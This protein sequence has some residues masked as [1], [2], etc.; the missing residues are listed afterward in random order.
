MRAALLLAVLWLPPAHAGEPFAEAWVEVAADA[1]LDALA[2]TGAVPIEGRR[3]LP[4]G[5]VEVRVLLTQGASARLT[6]GGFPHRVVRRD[7]RRGPVPTGYTTP[8]ASAALLE[9]LAQRSPHAER[10]RI[11]ASVLGRPID[12]IVLGRP[13][14]EAAP[15][16]R[17]LGAHHG[18][19]AS[20]V[21]VALALA[22][23]LADA[24]DPRAANIVA[25]STVW[26]VP[27]VNPDG[28]AAGDRHNEHTVDLNRNY[29]FVWRASERFAGP[30]PFSEPET[31]AVRGL[32]QHTRAH[33]GM[34]LHSGAANL[35]W[36]W[37]HTTEPAPEAALLRSTAENYQALNTTPDFWITNGAAWYFTHGDCND[38]SYGR[39]GLPEFTLELTKRKT[40]PAEDIPVFV[41][42]HLDAL[43]DFLDRPP[44]LTGH[45][46]DPAGAGI[47][48]TISVDGRSAEFHTDPMT[49]R[50]HRF[51]A[52]ARSPLLVEAPGY[53]SRTIPPGADGELYIELTPAR[54][55][56]G[57]ATPSVVQGPR[58][59]VLP[60]G[61]SGPVT[62]RQAGSAEVVVDAVG[63]AADVPALAPGWWTA[64]LIDGTTLPRVLWSDGAGPARVS[65]WQATPELL[66][67]E[68][69]DLGPGSRAWAAVG[70][71][72]VLVALP[73]RSESSERL[74]L[75][76]G[77]IDPAQPI[78][79]ALWTGGSHI[80]L[81]DARNPHLPFDMF[82]EETI[83]A[84]G[85]CTIGHSAR[86]PGSVLVLVLLLWRRRR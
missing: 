47:D 7:H 55:G 82:A 6:A 38:W 10:V 18:D 36:V 29:D 76:L 77:G 86:G 28:V 71:E 67:I 39:F 13:S 40:P 37:N 41:A 84:I 79:V 56:S 65:G 44:D 81:A 17:L 52:G 68:G 14:T 8:E 69:A 27:M 61:A 45:V 21:E 23:V 63:G 58:R 83:E 16:A 43:L 75:D 48:A 51:V 50:F 3:R 30:A 19:E 33:V 11:G 72:R 64:V 85:A 24:D 42:D 60:T 32:G 49:G 1:R 53:T 70:S 35:G 57:W 2:A 20:S 46:V 80:G 9:E 22:E 25:E 66:T 5:Q 73:L 15:T 74:V 59:V 62:L 12:A 54:L 34:S 31:R 26:I 78:D 4:N